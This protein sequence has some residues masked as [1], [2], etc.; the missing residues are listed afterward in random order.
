[1]KLTKSEFKELIKESITEAKAEKSV[2]TPEAVKL[3][4]QDIDHKFTKLKADVTTYDE[5]KLKKIAK[6]LETFRLF[7]NKNI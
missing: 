2:T 7:L 5:K 4:I 1:M 6:E 3:M